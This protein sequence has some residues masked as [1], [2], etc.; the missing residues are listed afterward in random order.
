M[1][2]SKKEYW[3]VIIFAVLSAFFLTTFMFGQERA[4][5]QRRYFQGAK[6]ELSEDDKSPVYVRFK[7]FKQP[8]VF[9]FFQ[10]YRKSFPLSGDDEMR[11]V[12]QHRDAL[13]ETHHRYQQFYK[14]I[15]VIGAQYILHE[16]NDVVQSDNGHIIHGLQLN[17]N[18]T[19]TENTALNA[20][21]DHI[22][23]ETYMWE[24]ASNE[25]FLKKEQQN[26]NATFYPSGMLKLTAGRKELR[27]ENMRLVYRFDIYAA[28]PFGRFWVDVDAHS[29]EIVNSISRIHHADAP[30]SGASHYNG[31]V[32]FTADKF[33]DGQQT[34][35]RLRETARGGIQTYNMQNSTDFL[36][37]VDF[38]N[39]DSSFSDPSARSGVSVHWAAEGAYDYFSTEHNR[40]GFDDANSDI[41]NYVNYGQGFTNAFWDGTRFAFGGGDGFTTGPMV[42][43]DVVAHE[44][45]HAITQHSANLMLANESGALNES[46]S[47]IFGTAAEFFV[48]G[49]GGDWLKGEDVVITD[50]FF[51]GNFA[52]PNQNGLPDTY[53]GNY[54]GAF[55]D[56][57]G[58]E[59]DYGNVHTNSWVH[60]YWFYLLSEGGS[61][62]N[63][64]GTS[65]NV[66]GIGIE[67]AAQIAY[68]NLTVYLTPTSG[69]NDARIGSIEAAKDLFG[70]N[71]DERDAVE[72]AWT[73][74]GVVEP[75]PTA[76]ILVWD[77]KLGGQDY[78]GTF[79]A[80]YLENAGFTVEH[81]E[82]FPNSLNSFDAVFLSFGNNGDNNNTVFNDGMASDVGDY[83]ESGGSL[84]LEGGDALGFDQFGNNNLLDLFG[85]ESAIDGGTNPINN[86]E[87]DNDALTAS[88][89]FTSS[90]QEQNDF[91]DEYTL[92][93]GIK[94]FTEP[95]AG[96]VA[97]Q[98]VGANGQKTF[99]FA[100]ALGGLDDFES[101]STKDDLM[102]RLVDFLVSGTPILN[103]TPATFTFTVPQNAPLASQALV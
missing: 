94:A 39:A 62:V 23:A 90:S 51:T 17:V 71:S 87:G 92:G 12:R 55:A 98:H 2:S 69:F 73:A 34:Q 102:D 27:S 46:F 97:V 76:Q 37:S 72:D 86:L 93:D 59:N 31:V 49:V 48:E 11:P 53:V 74:I 65:Y 8:T 85:I 33:N 10:E 80:N 35:Y 36:T 20:A 21:L 61:G 45:T 29:G 101:P 83:L 24:H 32:N 56:I 26:P 15:E 6:I 14:G 78:S 95:Q 13:G 50:P 41:L 84:Y 60:N 4:A 57:P 38:E 44:F 30:A 18:S 103:A 5:K 3:K 1:T 52:D 70:N 91:I 79:I 89:N 99:A 82:D 67:S 68:R 47:D 19:L 63:D 96:T 40:D 58:P 88:M 16:K 43:I 7:P 22:D 42:A 28:N 64:H 25:E 66:N 75:P 9:T 81:T 77:G 100:Y 54:W